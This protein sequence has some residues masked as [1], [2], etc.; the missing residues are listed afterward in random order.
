MAKGATVRQDHSGFPPVVSGINGQH[1]NCKD[2]PD[3]P[4]AP[5]SH[6]IYLADARDLSFIPDASV[7]LVVTSPPYFNLKK[8]AG[9]VEA[10]MGDIQE[11]EEFLRELDK[12]VGECARV[13]VPGGRVC[14]VVGAV[15]IAR[16]NGGRH[17]VLP[18]P[19]DIQV[20][21]RR[22][23]LDNLTPIMWHKVSN[24]LLEASDSSRFLGKP[25]LP[26]GIV[27]NDLETIVMLRKPG[28]YRK[29]TPEME[30]ASFITNEEYFKWFLP[31]WSDITGASTKTLSGK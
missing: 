19:S 20:R 13:L 16:R 7:H 18:L 2:I 6:E 21:C 25:N 31:I 4:L 29:P 22:L 5:S 12:V 14:C 3:R 26:N 17:H 8:Y 30:R 11:Y 23:G 24:I 1:S 27:K 15:T 9:D 28:G 10:Q